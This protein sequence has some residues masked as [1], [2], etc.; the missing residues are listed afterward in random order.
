[1]VF[2]PGRKKELNCAKSLRPG[3][4]IAG[5]GLVGEGLDISIDQLIQSSL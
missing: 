3:K 2:E 5:R 4:G 1:M